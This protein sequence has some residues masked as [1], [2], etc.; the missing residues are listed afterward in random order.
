MIKFILSLLIF[1]QSPSLIDSRSEFELS[2]V[3]SSYDNNGV[4]FYNLIKTDLDEILIGSSIGVLKWTAEGLSLIDK[5]V[6]SYVRIRSKKRNGYYFDQALMGEIITT[7]KFNYLLP[8]SYSNYEIPYASI[9]SNLLLV[10]NGKLYFFKKL[11]Y[12]RYLKGKSIRSISQNYV[13]TYNGIFKND[14]LQ[15]D[16]PTYTNS[17]IR[18]FG[19]QVIINFDGLSIKDSTG[20]TEHRGLIGN[21][22]CNGVDLGYALDVFKFNHTYILFTTKGIWRTT[23]KDKPTK[24]VEFDKEVNRMDTENTP[25]FIDFIESN[26]KEPPRILIYANRSLEIINL[27]NYE[28]VKIKTILE[29]A[30]D[31]KRRDNLTC[32]IDKKNINILDTN[33]QIKPLVSNTY[34]FHTLYPIN[35]NYIVLTSDL[36]LFRFNIQSKELTKVID[37]EFNRL[38]LYQKNDSLLIGGVDGLIKYPI[39]DFINYKPLKFNSSF[40]DKY[41]IIIFLCLVIVMLLILKFNKKTIIIEDA[42]P[43][44]E[45]QINGFISNNLSNASVIGIQK[46]FNISYRQLSKIYEPIGP[47]KKI[48]QIRKEKTLE[49]IKN[50]DDITEITKATGYSVAYLKKYFKIT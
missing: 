25:K 15:V 3:I 31:I 11:N 18:E 37:S 36:G 22:E 42:A 48:E 50:G 20:I 14:K 47:G 29:G 1:I 28:T 23:V 30:I 40:D 2:E 35:D 24:I 17:Y 13:G 9:D 8:V 32:W 38:A 39:K 4:V 10:V 49:M 26:D 21:F 19:N 12:I 44:I 46:E 41:L 6:L 7:K 27:N 34:D 45:N 43:S 16:L 33:N 5:S